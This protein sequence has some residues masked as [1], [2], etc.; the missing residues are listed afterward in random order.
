MSAPCTTR[1]RIVGNP[2]HAD[3][4]PV[5]R[6]LLSPVPLRQVFARYQFLTYPLKETLHS[7]GPQW[8]RMSTPS[9]PG[10]PSFRSANAY[11]SRSVF[12]LADVHEQAPESPFRFSLRLHVYPSSQVPQSDRR[13]YHLA[14]ASHV[15]KVVTKQQGRFP[16]PALPGF[17]GTTNPSATLSPVGRFPGAAGLYGLPCSADFSPGR[18]GLLQLLSAS[19]SPCRPLP[20]RQSV[21]ALQPVCAT[22]CC[23]RPT[24]TDSASRAS[25]YRGYLCVHSRYGPVTRRP[26]LRWPCQWASDHRFPSSLPSKLRG[27]GSYPGGSVPR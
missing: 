4:A 25:D 21:I 2:Q 14:S 13:L 23:L 22:P 9:I 6:Y 20:P 10:L 8:P 16:P 19:S 26:P 15:A 5:L 1:S 17:P 11:A 7:T 3:L 27:S 24:E 12:Q 18:G